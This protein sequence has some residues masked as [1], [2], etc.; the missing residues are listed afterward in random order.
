[1]ATTT[2]TATQ[3]YV[4]KR[5][6]RTEDPRLITGT[7]TYVDDITREGMLYTAVLRSP[8]AAA[9]ISSIAIEKAAALPGVRA[10]YTGE[11]VK[12]VGPVPCAGSMPT[13][14]VPHHAILAQDRVYYVGHPVA[15]V[16]ATD[17]YV[18]Q[19]AV[20][21]IEVDYEPTDSVADPEKALEEGS[22]GFTRNIR[23][24][25]RLPTTRTVATS[26]RLLPKPM[27]W[28]ASGL[29]FRDWRLRR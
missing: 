14:R 8:H 2:T 18:A 9:K 28:S 6:R 20:E 10:V 22:V 29:Q 25:S 26:G 12:D 19:D 16:V 21:L 3:T 7:A 11:D 23:T 17:R 24:T 27:W 15:A 13:L 4:G 1:M 5:V